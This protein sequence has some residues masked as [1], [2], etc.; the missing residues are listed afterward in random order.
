M[1]DHNDVRELA[2]R[3]GFFFQTSEAYGG[4][5]G[6][7]TFGPTGATLKRN[8]EEAWRQQFVVK[9][10]NMEIEAPTVMAEPVFEAS[11]HLDGFDD[12]L[13]GC[14]ECDERT[15]ADHIVEDAPETGIEE[16]ESLPTDQVEEIIA[17]HDLTCP[18]CEA[19]LAGQEV[20]EFNL[21]FETTIGPGSGQ[22]G[23]LRPETAQGIFVEF[24]RLKEYA[25]NKLP[26]GVT[27][28]GRSYR[29]EINPR[30]GLVRVREFTQAELELFIDPESDE[31]PLEKVRDV[32]VTL[33][34][35]AAQEAEDGQPVE[36]T[37][38]DA[39]DD[40]II[41]SD[42][43]A[44]Y[45]GIAK[46]WYEQIG[47]DMGRFRYRQHR[48]GEL[49]HYAAD[50]WDAEAEV[51]GD[52]VEI[53]GFAYRSD[54]DLH[55]HQEHSGEGNSYEVFHEYD[56]Q[57]T[58]ERPVV[59]PDMSVL[60]PE[61]GDAAPVVAEALQELAERNPS[62]FE[63]EEVT[64]EVKGETVNISTDVA[65]F[66][67][68]KQTETGEHRRPHVVE[69]SFG[70]DRIVYALIEHAM[71][72][73]AAE[74]G[75]SDRQFLALEPSVAPQFAGVFPME[76]RNGVQAV[77]NDLV[78]DLRDAGVE[79]MLD[80]SGSI[81]RR[82]YRQ[83]EVGTPFCITVDPAGLDGEGPDVVTLRERD[84]TDQ[85][86]IPLDK[87]VDVLVRLQAG[88]I[89]FDEVRDQYPLRG[90]NQTEPIGFA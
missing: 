60:G 63:E 8:V 37:I 87:V 47:I 44:Y 49:A 56:E 11:G 50:C 53:T 83:D 26:F 41:A 6:F 39:V 29:N 67:Y 5:G 2:K 86:W 33:Y 64:I 62:A 36:M 58:V 65:G 55:K 25:R 54:Y 69:P 7:F 16:A 22:S 68:E 3:R 31:P 81:G 9:E 43:V 78:D 84:T 66:R 46:R 42:W 57:K 70:I 75:Q 76:S 32:E 52:W 1:S 82:Y 15:R 14:P 17:E 34:P 10:G 4:T 59:D 89:S 80:E 61:F 85:V 13:V 72:V 45:L 51:G 35:Q 38:G 90:S 79:A 71:R 21:M 20:T 18:N 48:S 73:E 77:A 28:I 74:N 40:G 27:Q 19:P 30:K 88:S 23:F 24:P 12:M